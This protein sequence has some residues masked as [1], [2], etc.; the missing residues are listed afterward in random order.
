MAAARRHWR[1]GV[2]PCDACRQAE[3]EYQ[4]GRHGWKP[5]QPATCGTVSGYR[6]HRRDGETACRQCKAANAAA[7]R[8]YKARRTAKQAAA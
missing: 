7:A 6:R 1:D 5:F 3:L 2:E 8:K 4:R